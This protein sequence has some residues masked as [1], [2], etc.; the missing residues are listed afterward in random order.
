RVHGDV[1]DLELD[2][3]GAAG[4]RP[5]A[6]HVP[7]PVSLDAGR[8]PGADHHDEP[9]PT[10]DEGQGARG[11][12]LPGQPQE[13]DVDRPD[14]ARPERAGAAAPRPR[15]A[16]LAVARGGPGAGPGDGGREA[17]A[18]YAILR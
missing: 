18:R 5:A 9:E 17:V 15:A 6:V 16:T 3:E 1:D 13:R 10:V 4:V 2:P 14:P 11:Q 8:A 7:E 12:R